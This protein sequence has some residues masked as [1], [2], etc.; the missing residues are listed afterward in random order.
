MRE[1]LE[2][3]IV[4]RGDCCGRQH[5]HSIPIFASPHVS[6][7]FFGITK[8]KHPRQ[9]AISVRISMAVSFS[10]Q[11]LRRSNPSEL[12]TDLN[13]V[14]AVYD[15]QHSD[16]TCLCGLIDNLLKELDNAV[17]VLYAALSVQTWIKSDPCIKCGSC[18]S[19]HQ[20]FCRPI[21]RDHLMNWH[22]LSDDQ[23]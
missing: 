21:S 10:V 8:G 2:P 5:F 12:S 3:I 6:E 22:S 20:H 11:Q 18:R 13:G 23:Y 19:G 4:G 7:F 15:E 1:E 9:G 14:A 17:A 16:R